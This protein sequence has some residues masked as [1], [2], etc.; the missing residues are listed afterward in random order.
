MC[1]SQRLQGLLRRAHEDTVINGEYCKLIETGDKI[2][3]SGDVSG[4]EG[5]KCKDREG[6][7]QP[8]WR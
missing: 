8:F 4:D 5:G 1:I 6:V 7:H 2:P 3:A